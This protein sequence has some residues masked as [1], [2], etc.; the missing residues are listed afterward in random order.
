[1]ILDMISTKGERL[2]PLT[3][4]WVQGKNMVPG[5]NTHKTEFVLILCFTVYVDHIH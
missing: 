2:V 4:S 5:L 3:I 1:M